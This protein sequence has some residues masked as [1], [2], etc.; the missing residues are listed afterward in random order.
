MI[1]IT[2]CFFI[3]FC[4]YHKNVIYVF[5]IKKY[6][7][8]QFLKVFTTI[9]VDFFDEQ[10]GHFYIYIFLD[11]T[12]NDW[13]CRTLGHLKTLYFTVLRH[14]LCWQIDILI[15]KIKAV[16]LRSSFHLADILLSISAGASARWGRIE[17][18]LFKL[19]LRY[20]KAAYKSGRI[21]IK[22]MRYIHVVLSR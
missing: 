5:R 9:V 4:L 1:I 7:P 6:R 10:D 22:W 3:S 11:F 14:R 12:E 16:E 17:R 21:S 18:C 13:L 2:N 15:F 8:F 19:F 20:L